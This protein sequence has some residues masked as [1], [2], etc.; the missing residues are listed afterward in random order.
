MCGGRGQVQQRLGFLAV[1][2]TCPNCRGRGSIIES[3]C[4]D[5]TGTGRVPK[6]ASIDVHVPAGIEDNVR[7]RVTGQGELGGRRARGDLYCYV[8]VE[9]HP[10]FERRGDDVI[11]RAPITYSQ[12]VLGAEIQVPTLEESTHR[13]QVPRGTQSGDV[14]TLRGLG[15]P[16][17]NRRGRGHEH[18]LVVID[19]PNKVNERQETLLRELATLEDTHVSP[20]RKSFFDKLKTFFSEE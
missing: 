19:V 7:L 2:A 15:V 20:Q 10:L 4:Q 9:P 17:L 8:R 6:R 5:C 16:H 12:A 18:V 14:L 1:P 13:L 3:P 11:C